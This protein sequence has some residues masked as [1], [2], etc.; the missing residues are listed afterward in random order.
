MNEEVYNDQQRN[1]D[2][3]VYVL[4]KKQPEKK[5]VFL[6]NGYY[7]TKVQKSRELIS[8][9]ETQIYNLIKTV[10]L[11]AIFR[12]FPKENINEILQNGK[13]T[14]NGPKIPPTEVIFKIDDLVLFIDEFFG[15]NFSS[16]ISRS[17]TKLYDFYL[18]KLRYA[19]F[20]EK[21]HLPS[22]KNIVDLFR[23]MNTANVKSSICTKFLMGYLKKKTLQ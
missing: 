14:F 10:M 3:Y 1:K 17:V 7:I 18:I 6:K 21:I 15:K 12:I 4:S 5:N 2:R 19:A 20:G 23:F 22:A 8:Y 9:S 16:M 11:M 13:V